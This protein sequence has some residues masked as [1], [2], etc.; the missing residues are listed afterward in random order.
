[1]NLFGDWT[2]G[3]FSISFVG[4]TNVGSVKVHFDDNLRT[5][6]PSP[7]APYINDRN[8][9]T[10][11]A[12]NNA[13]FGYPIRIRGGRDD[14]PSMFEEETLSIDNMLQ[15]FDVKD[16]IDIKKDGSQFVYRPS[17]EQQLKYNILNGFKEDLANEDQKVAIGEIKPN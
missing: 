10:L 7:Q 13:F 1:V 17:D 12:A 3:F 14:T 8:Y 6:V 9:A 2:H 15:E 16:I 11:S 4:A 5:N